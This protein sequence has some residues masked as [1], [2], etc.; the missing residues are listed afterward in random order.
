M[1]ATAKPGG[2]FRFSMIPMDLSETFFLRKEMTL[3]PF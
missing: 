1:K 2:E 3:C